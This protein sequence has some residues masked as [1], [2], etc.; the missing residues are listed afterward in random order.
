MKGALKILLEYWAQEQQAAGAI[1]EEGLVT[2]LDFP[3]NPRQNPFTQLNVDTHIRENMNGGDNS[4]SNLDEPDDIGATNGKTWGGNGNSAMIGEDLSDD[5][6]N[7]S[8]EVGEEVDN[9][10]LSQALGPGGNPEENERDAKLRSDL[11][12]LR[13]L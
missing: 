9:S 13:V 12:M 7:F 1:T 6:A 10:Q 8:A 3:L 5:E 11:A 4:M 2:D